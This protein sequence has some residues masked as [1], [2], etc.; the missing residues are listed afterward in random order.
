LKVTR[1]RSRP[2]DQ[3]TGVPAPRMCK[4]ILKTRSQASRTPKFTQSSPKRSW[5]SG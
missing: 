5:H 4:F 1:E 3:S 2:I